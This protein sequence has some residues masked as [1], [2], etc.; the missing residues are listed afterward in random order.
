MLS[1]NILEVQFTFAKAHASCELAS[2]LLKCYCALFYFYNKRYKTK[3]KQFFRVLFIPLHS[4]FSNSMSK[5]MCLSLSFSDLSL[6]K[7]FYHA[8]DFK[9]AFCILLSQSTFELNKILNAHI[10]VCSLET[11]ITKKAKIK[12]ANSVAFTKRCSC[13]YFDAS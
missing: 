5:S 2:Y 13:I 4:S 1:K 3:Q 12:A 10:N 7:T 11:E 8:L 9:L 6:I